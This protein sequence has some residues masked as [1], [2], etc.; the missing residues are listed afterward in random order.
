VAVVRR[1]SVSGAAVD[2]RVVQSS[3]NRDKLDGTGPSGLT[4]DLTK[5]FILAIDLLWYGYGR[6]RVGFLINGLHIQ[7]HEFT[8]ANV[9]AV[10]YM[11]TASLPIRY[12]IAN[13]AV[14]GGNNTM[15][16]SCAA[17][18][19]EDGTQDEPGL[20][21]SASTGVASV[22]VTTRRAVISI[23][24][25]TTFGPSAKVN[26]I[27]ITLEAF[28]ALT[29]TNDA[30]YEVVYNPTF[31]GTP[32]W[33]D[34]TLESAVEYS[35]HGDAAAG[36]IT[37]GIVVQSGYLG[38]GTGVAR[39]AVLQAPLL[40]KLPL[41][42]DAAGA[43]PLAVSLVITSMTGTSNNAAAVSWKEVR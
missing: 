40:S 18:M 17:V 14:Q 43:T 11:K 10:P 34:P 41:T 1:S 32:V 30:F 8:A 15:T 22:A 24:P 12:E 35:L 31:T 36:A 9:I 37:G 21:F 16:Q 27:P 42:L 13:T 39:L 28:S 5:G 2:T 26:R 7:V 25:K 33:V 20:F 4:L 6:V 29:G 3:W 19:T 23:R 38:S